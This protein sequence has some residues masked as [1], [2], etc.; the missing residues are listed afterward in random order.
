MSNVIIHGRD[1]KNGGKNRKNGPL[2]VI[3]TLIFII[4]AL[5]AL[6]SFLSNK[7]KKDT[8]VIQN[9]S[10][11][12]YTMGDINA[13]IKIVEY[14]DF[15]CPACAGFASVF[16]KAFEEINTKYGSSTLSLTYK[17][18]PL[19]S[20]HKNALL[21]AQSAEAAKMQGKFWEMS[22]MLFE[23]QDEWANTLDAK[24]KIEGYAREIGLDMTKF[25]SDRDSESVKDIINKG[26]M[27]ATKLKLSHTP[28]VFINGEEMKDFTLTKESIV[29]VIEDKM[30][31]IGIMPITQ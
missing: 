9:I 28:F 26:L 17:Y 31:Q 24:S 30:I 21:S 14:S 10:D 20:I 25:I 2:V 29:K 6:N 12:S 19:I 13:K 1:E 5:F 27:E 23:K 11:N 4:A 16:G 18:F 3:I 8:K 15:E 7:N 22:N